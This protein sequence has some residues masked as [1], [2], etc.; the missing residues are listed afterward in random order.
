MNVTTKLSAMF[1][2]PNYD[3]DYKSLLGLP[4]YNAD[5][6]KT[7]GTITE[8]N[9]EYDLLFIDITDDAAIKDAIVGRLCECA[10][11]GDP[12]AEEPLGMT[13]IKD[14]CYG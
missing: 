2:D 3:Y 10:M 9:L 14:D 11:H 12:N 4:L 5:G 1:P 13:N 8:V 7:I 6:D